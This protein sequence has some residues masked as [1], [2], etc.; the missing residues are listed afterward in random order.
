VELF[1]NI[2][3]NK[4][5]L[6]T[7]NTGFKGS[8]LSAWLSNLGA[9]LRGLSLDIPTKP[10]FFK[11][12]NLDELAPTD[13]A[14]ICN[15]EFVLNLLD[16][17]KPDFI[18]HL[19]AQ[20]IVLESYKNPLNTWLANTI[21]TAT[22][23]EALRQYNSDLKVIFIT[24]DKVYDNVEWCWGYKETDT[25]GGADP[26][27]ASKGGAELAISSYYRSFFHKADHPVKLII[28]RAGNVIGGG[29]WSSNRIV[30]DAIHS[31]QQKKVLNLRNPSSTRPWQHVL[32][33]ISGY[34]SLGQK[35]SENPSLSGQSFNF[36][37]PITN[38]FS[39]IELVQEMSIYWNGAK[40]K[41]Q[42][43]SQSYHEAGLLKLNCEKANTLLGWYPIW[44]FK[45]TAEKTIQWYQEFYNAK[46][47][48]LDFTHNQIDDYVKSAHLVKP[49]WLQD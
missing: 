18:F 17:F 12:G 21:G 16:R 24:S 29:D 48:I 14:D 47:N 2:Y 15:L 35:L 32:E 11:E 9:Q 39:V 1:N 46:S 42:E 3:K 13:F 44:D 31:W 6:I 33:P 19:A 5:I 4:N 8:W 10:S 22:L 41:V 7:G 37:P 23:L 36:G 28:G 27:S 34:L 40:F 20:P 26:Y 49:S 45:T 30:P 38:N 25:I 43:S